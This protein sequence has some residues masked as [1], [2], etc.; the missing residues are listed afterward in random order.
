[1]RVVQ[2]TLDEE[3]IKSVDYLVRQLGK[4]RS[5]FTREALREAVHRYEIRREEERHRQGYLK[6]P[7]REPELNDWEEEQEWGD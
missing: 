1:M 2:M 7:V 3:L 5:E 4:T 6:N